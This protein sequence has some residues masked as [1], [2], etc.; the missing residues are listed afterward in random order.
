MF[1]SRAFFRYSPY[2]AIPALGVVGIVALIFWTFLAYPT[3][4]SDA[5][6]IGKMCGVNRQTDRFAVDD[7]I[8]RAAKRYVRTDVFRAHLHDQSAMQHE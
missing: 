8:E 7:G 4:H 1:R 5:T 6:E 2:D 3:F